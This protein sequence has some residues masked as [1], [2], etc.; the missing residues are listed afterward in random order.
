MARKLS[1]RVSALE[2]TLKPTMPRPGGYII[3]VVDYC[4]ETQAELDKLEAETV[5]PDYEPPECGP[6]QYYVE[7]HWPDSPLG[8]RYAYYLMPDDRRIPPLSEP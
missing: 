6:D 5:G 7:H 4:P 1:T 3:E 8:P 2:S